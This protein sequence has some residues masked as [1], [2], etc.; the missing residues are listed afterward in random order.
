MNPNRSYSNQIKRTSQLRFPVEDVPTMTPTKPASQ[1]T[2]QFNS[3]PTAAE[4]TPGT[5]AT[6]MKSISLKP[7]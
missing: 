1:D 4:S 3:L 7:T 5:N 6:K 2:E